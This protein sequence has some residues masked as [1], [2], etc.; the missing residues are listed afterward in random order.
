MKEIFKFID[1]RKYLAEYYL[2]KKSSTRHFSYR[3]FA[4]RAGIKSP[5]F[6][7]QVIDGER[8]LTRQMIDK[9]IPALGLN[10]KEGSFFKNL[11]L[12]NQAKNAAEKQECYSL[13]LS[14]MAYVPE[15][16]ISGDQYL[17]FEQWYNSAIRE[18]ICLH[19][20]QDD[21][22]RIAK[23]VK[24]RIKVNEAKK[25]VQLLLRLKLI[26]Q[27]KDGT[28]RQTDSAIISSDS[29]VALARRS[30]N[31]EMLMLAKDANET[32]P[33]AER[34]ISGMTMGISRPCYDVLLAEL[35]AF[36]E[37]VKAIVN[38]DG[39]SNR[40]YQLNFQL[41]PLSEDPGS[42]RKPGIRSELCGE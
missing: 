12:F 20:F 33:P 5:V 29:M 19:D 38:Q 15:R 28:Y 27:R 1:Y 3:F 14:M 2:E 7:K 32:L 26:A 10:K 8:N 11:V 13:M 4:Q 9:F 42:L 37:R 23:T 34:N 25:A 17:Y 24:P 6:L 35:S 16:Q 31:S 21:F 30:F 41:F 39:Q 22:D 40:V 18:L 36:K